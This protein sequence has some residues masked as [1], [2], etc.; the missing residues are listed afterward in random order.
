MSAVLVTFAKSGALKKLYLLVLRSYV[1]PFLLSFA[2]VLFILVI[3][4]LALYMDEIFGKDLGPVVIMKLFYYAGARLVVTAMPA[5][6]LAA[7]LITFG[8]MG[9]HYELAAIKSCGIGLM[10]L[11][12]PMMVVALLLTAFSLWFSFTVIP[13]ANLKFFSLLYDVQRK[14]AD[15]AV[16]PGYF[17]SDIDGYVIRVSDKNSETGMMYD[18]LLYDHTENR[19]NINVVVADS[20]R[21][22]VAQGGHKL[23][24][25][26][27]HGA[28]HEE[29]KPK[30]GENDNYPLGRSYFDSLYY[31]FN[32][33]GF[34][35]DRTDEKLFSRHQITLPRSELLTSIDSIE[36]VD[37]LTDRKF[38]EYLAPY[39]RL[40]TTILDT[41]T[42]MDTL[43]LDSIIFP[44]VTLRP[45]E[46]LLSKFPEMNTVDILNKAVS[47]ARAIKN[48][49]DF[50]INKKDDDE[51]TRRKFGIEFHTMHSIPFICILFMLIGVS[52]GAIIRKGGLGMP[53]LI[54]ILFFVIFYVLMS[55]GRKLAKEGVL[56][57]WF[58]SWLPV[59][60]L[61]PVAIALTWQAA[62]DSRFLDESSREMLRDSIRN[63]F[64][65]LFGR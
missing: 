59:I 27:Y 29:M 25:V 6:I 49:T 45:G 39:T 58:G 56:D 57:P 42:S 13:G 53:S 3:Q 4:F 41:I 50:V 31:H 33:S 14:K 28:R 52:L 36:K 16:K 47:D 38:A 64:R 26:L 32:L 20:A 8:N 18:V 10:R 62:M 34:D 40:D 37:T 65:K 17:Y 60:V 54:S 35:L 5:A 9:E 12:R 15:I 11:M 24:M 1:G 48:Y 46:D 61:T 43:Q 44:L 51:K 55:Q 23:N 63:L 30:E 21:M 2:V 22:F 7:G 19:G